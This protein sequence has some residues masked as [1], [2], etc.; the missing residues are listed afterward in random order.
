MISDH[1]PLIH[2]LSAHE[3]KQPKTKIQTLD[4]SVRNICN[5]NN[6]LS[7]LSW[8]DI[9]QENDTQI[10]LNNFYDTFHS[11]MDLSIPN[12]TKT[13]N[14]NFHNIEPWMT[15]GILNSRHTKLNLEKS[16]FNNPSAVSLER[17]K[18]FCNLYNKTVK[19]ARKIYF[20]N[21]LEEHQSD[22][23]KCWSLTKKAL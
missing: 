12:V 21:E 23:K 20:E 2:I 16:H 17:Y 14:R 13:F 22:A 1:F 8:T 15:A 18:K 7:V 10:A 5:L 4:Y 11:F 6:A 19:L 9:I 3:A